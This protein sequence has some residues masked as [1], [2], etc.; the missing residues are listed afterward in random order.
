[1]RPLYRVIL[2]ILICYFGYVAF[3][4]TMEAQRTG[5]FFVIQHYNLVVLIILLL[6]AV[7]FDTKAY[8]RQHKLFQFYSSGTGLFLCGIVL[9]RLFTFN[10]I[11]KSKT[12]FTALP[13]SGSAVCYQVTFKE[14]DKLVIRDLRSQVP[15]L[16][17]GNYNK[18][19]DSII[20]TASNW[21]EFA[22]VLPVSG[23][24]QNGLLVWK[25]GD[26]LLIRKD[27]E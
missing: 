1:M 8:Q 7:V 13:K 3:R 6:M 10:S 26:T 5:M 15:F 18:N 9:F 27:G 23:V 14:E 11:E 20:I 19:R 22:A 25:S 24:I 12:I 4:Q 2:F 21:E 16:Y 17:Y